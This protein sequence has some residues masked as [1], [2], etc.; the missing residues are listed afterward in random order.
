MTINSTKVYF[1]DEFQQTLQG[2]EFPKDRGYSIPIPANPVTTFGWQDEIPMHG[3]ARIGPRE[4]VWG[5]ENKMT[6]R[7]D[8]EFYAP[9]NEIRANVIPEIDVNNPVYQFDRSKYT[10]SVF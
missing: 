4:R 10:Y 8:P 2:L 5:Q 7:A 1:V 9:N 3:D 6:T